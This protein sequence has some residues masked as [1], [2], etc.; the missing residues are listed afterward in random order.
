[1][2]ESPAVPENPYVGPLPFTETDPLFGRDV[3]KVELLNILI[4]ER[5]V[6]LYS[7]SGAGKTSLIQAGL[8]PELKVAHFR[9]LPIIRV[10]RVLEPAISPNRYVASAIA[11]LN[12]SRDGTATFPT[13]ELTGLTLDGYLTRLESAAPSG[14]GGVADPVV[15][16]FDQFEEILTADPT[17]LAAKEAFFAEVGAALQPRH[18][19]ALFAMREEHVAAL[20]PYLHLIPTR[21]APTMSFSHE[22]PTIT[23]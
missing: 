1:M 10:N 2:G 18:R 13:A 20:D 4:A 8:L 3:E 17:D 7:P 16:I 9:P 5:I 23:T 19:W 11:A 12:T 22:S 14:P 15:L 6:L 21:L